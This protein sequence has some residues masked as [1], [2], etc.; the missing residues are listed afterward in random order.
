MDRPT[1]APPPIRPIDVP[2]LIITGLGFP[3]SQLAI[4]LMGRKGA[5]LVEMVAAALVIRDLQLLSTGSADRPRPV[6]AALLYLETGAASVVVVLGLRSLTSHGIQEATARKPGPWEIVR[7][8][9]LGTLFGL[10]TWRFA[11]RRH[12]G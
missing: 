9:A 4:K 5:A 12:Q 7:R 2:V 1:P 3:L 10:H 11:M 8:V 6:P